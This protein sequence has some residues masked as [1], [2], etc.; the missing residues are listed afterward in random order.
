MDYLAD[1]GVTEVFTVAGGGAIFLDDALAGT[2]RL[3]YYCCHHEQAVA[4]ATEAYARVAG[5]IG[6]SL[7]TTW[8][9]PI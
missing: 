9:L 8:L 6:V 7:V 5:D 2:D 4:I 1:I 3:R